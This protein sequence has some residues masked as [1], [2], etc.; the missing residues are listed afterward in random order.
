M[1]NKYIVR[2]DSLISD[3]RQL[4][5]SQFEG[6]DRSEVNFDDLIWFHID[7]RSGR[8]T[9]Y[10]CGRHGVMGRGSSGNS[11]EYA[12]T[13]P[14]S[15]L[16][17][18]WVLEVVN[19]PISAREKKARVS[20]VRKFLSFMDGELYNQNELTISKE[21]MSSH[22][23]DRIRPFFE[24]C[25]N[26]GLM[27]R[28]ELK[29]TENRDRTGNA[30]FEKYTNKIPQV[31]SLL[32]LGQMFSTI[33]QYVNDDGSV[34]EGE[35]V[36]IVDAWVVTFALAGL[37]SPSRLSAEVSVLPKQRLKTY[38]EG[39]GNPVHYLDWKGSKG[40]Q[41]NKTHVLGALA[42]P[43]NKA[44]NYFFLKCE[45]ARI[46]C[47]FYE[48]PDLSL[49]KLLGDFKIS[50]DRK[51]DHLIFS[52]PTNLFTLGYLLGFYGPEDSVPTLKSGADV[53]G[54]YHTQRDQFFD[55][56]PIYALTSSDSLSMS[57]TRKTSFSSLPF[58]FGYEH[59]P[60]QIADDFSS[61]LTATIGEIQDWWIA[62]VKKTLLPAFPR[63]Y[64]TSE[65]S[66][67]LADA[68]FC[69]RG[70]WVFARHDGTGSGGGAFQ[71]SPFAIV[72]L[73]T[74]SRLASA[75]LIGTKFAQTIFED[76]GF[77]KE[78]LIRPHTL[79]HFGNTLADQS[80][81]PHEIITAWSG[82]RNPEQTTTYIHTS[83]EERADRVSAIFN[84]PEN[85]SREIRV[86]AQEDL[87]KL[88]NL[89]ATITSTG[90][91]TQDLNSTPCD[92]LNDFV[93]QCFLCSEA[94]HIAGDD[95]A[96]AFLE[97]DYLY[98]NSRLDTVSADHRLPVSQAMQR[99]YIIHSRNTYI[100]SQLLHLMKTSPKGSVIRFSKKKSE[101]Y[102]SDLQT[103]SI[104]NQPCALPDFDGT[105]KSLIES[106]A[107]DEAPSSNPKLQSLLSCFGLSGEGT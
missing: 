73:S 59:L 98:Q 47:R 6:S 87:I 13:Y 53:S 67:R 101:F 27:R 16:V 95:K 70:D 62:L 18:V 22:F 78:L 79:R 24:F 52:K 17:K 63:D 74:L 8:K 81:I 21:L 32:A 40:F 75:K 45:P 90:V 34:C 55:K 91:C 9:R 65:S 76:Y 105:L 89:P 29:V 46:L 71:A 83:H 72:P 85:D 106:R 104:T 96:I 36:N 64:S 1:L 2:L 14:Y 26:K 44:I 88:A 43:Y 54:V 107:K 35:T 77:S 69:I 61:V 15:H 103:K 42:E 4:S 28:I 92:Y 11:L 49:S 58:L 50:A 80:N 31:E 82:R 56:R 7:P 5:L 3:Y 57:L 93:S 86:I 41:D 10:Y 100:L 51:I 38:A 23:S 94:C 60:K 19:M 39:N 84:L 12:L 37:A 99:W 30:V 66:V 25:F 33:F 102:L 20:V 97:K 68:L 48:N